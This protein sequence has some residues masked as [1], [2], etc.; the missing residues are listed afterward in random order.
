[1]SPLCA[2]GILARVAF[3][4]S[5]FLV[6]LVHYMTFEGFKAMTTEGLGALEILGALWAYIL[7][8]LMILGGGLFVVGRYTKLATWTAGV[9]LVSIPI[10]VLLKPVLSGVALPDVMPFAIDA[11]IWLIVFVLVVQS[12]QSAC[13]SD[14]DCSNDDE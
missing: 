12:S 13:C 1:M 14:G 9:A 8:A 4:V 10:G 6:G 7:P 5:L 11:F 2:V 3:G